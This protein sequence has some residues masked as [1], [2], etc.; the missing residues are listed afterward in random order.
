MGDIGKINIR[1]ARYDEAFIIGGMWKELM[2][3]TGASPFPITK[4]AIDNYS[5]RIITMIG[6]QN[7][8]VFIAE[9]DSR[10]VGFITVELRNWDYVNQLY[11]HCENVYVHPMFRKFIIG[12]KLISTVWEWAKKMGGKIGVFNTVYDPKLIKRWTTLGFKPCGLVFW[13]EMNNG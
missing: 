2:E 1:L 13:K 5:I 6:A 12:K 10:P 8:E 11:G 4:E 9:H 7:S 3:E